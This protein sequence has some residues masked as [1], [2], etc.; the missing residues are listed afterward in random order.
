MTRERRS[1]ASPLTLRLAAA[2]L[3]VAV[4]SVATF[5]VIVAVVDRTDVND[6]A[7]RQEAAGAAALVATTLKAY[8]VAGGWSNADLTSVDALA[9]DT[10]IGVRITAATGA[11]IADHPTPAGRSGRHS[12]RPLSAAGRPIGTIT[13][14][15]PDRSL[16]DA[17]RRLRSALQR[18]VLV[19]AGVA[20]LVAL[21]AAVAVSSR[22][23]RPLR[24]LTAAV[25]ARGAGRSTGVGGRA[26]IGELG[27]L[28]RAFETM[29]ADLDRHEQ[30][31]RGLVADVA[32]ELRTPIAILQGELESIQDGV[33]PL[34]A[35]AVTSLHAEVLRLGRLIE[36]LQTL[37]AA[38]AAGLDLHVETV[39]LAD[40]AGTA[41]SAWRRA[42]AD[43]GLTWEQSLT[44]VMVE[45][46]PLRLHQVVTNVVAN[47]VKYT[48]AG[49]TVVLRV[50]G[51]DGQA[52]LEVRDDGPGIPPDQLPH[53]FERFQRGPNPG[54]AG[55][56]IGLAVTAA[57]VAAHHGTVHV[58]CPEEGGTRAVVR[59]PLAAQPLGTDGPDLV[60]HWQR[61]RHAGSGAGRRPGRPRRGSEG[62]RG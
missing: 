12:S 13:L 59:L 43:A 6:A 55:S 38:Q 25:I 20:A 4:A 11:L 22:I 56:G 3:T 51:E 46:D 10:R 39:D 8:D 34:T 14:A 41:A 62:W 18:S 2:F 60:T 16:S 45:G 36:D 54:V 49:G 57:L 21:I 23:T 48:P 27:D 50:S 7:R 24:E 17:D 37:A 47:A 30:L 58:D 35:A 52:V 31:R 40:V 1:R 29:V 61:P 9:D 42:A 19:A 15:W 53:I 26:G 33:T 44:A 28:A 32:H 5:A